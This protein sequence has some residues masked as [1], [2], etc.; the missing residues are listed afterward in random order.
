MADLAGMG[1]G[2]LLERGGERAGGWSRQTLKFPDILMQHSK[3][4]IKVEK[5]PEI[6]RILFIF[7]HKTGMRCRTSIE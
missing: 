2:P 4:T 7:I 1:G 6:G 3:K 5:K